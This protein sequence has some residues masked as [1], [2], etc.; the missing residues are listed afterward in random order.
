[1]NLRVNSFDYIRTIAIFMIVICHYLMFSGINEGVAR[2]LASTGNVM[3]FI[4]SALLYG[5]KRMEDGSFVK[6]GGGK[7]LIKRLFKLGASAW[8]FLIV[9]T[10]CFIIY[11]VNFRWVDIGLNFAFMGYIAKLPGNG[12]L[13]FLTVMMMCYVECLLVCRYYEKLRSFATCFLLVLVVMMIVSESFGFPG[14]AFAILGLYGFVLLK[15]DW[16][17][18]KAKCMG[19]IACICTVALNVIT[20]ILDNEGLFLQYRIIHYLLTYL[21]GISLLALLV[22]IM[23]EKENKAIRFISGISFEMYLVHHTLCNGPIVYITLW[24]ISIVSQVVLLFLI[25]VFLAYVLH[26][27]A[28]RLNHLFQVGSR[29]VYA[30][31]R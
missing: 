15:R 19:K 5:G 13:W 4:L 6:N 21:C 28:I 22:K 26:L 29:L 27:I 7:F 14:N 8:P 11:D 20:L 25:T 23:P 31:F 3:F 9:L 10:I 24:H 17:L 18:E 30:E 12:H 2:Y 1:M 16:F